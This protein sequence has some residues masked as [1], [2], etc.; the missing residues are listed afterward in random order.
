MFDL[1][2]LAQSILAPSN[3]AKKEILA[4]MLEAIRPKPNKILEFLSY[5]LPL[6]VVNYRQLFTHYKVRKFEITAIY[7]L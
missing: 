7:F 3:D 4:K 5:F 1:E 6:A 2:E